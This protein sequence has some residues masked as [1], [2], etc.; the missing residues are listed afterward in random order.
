M[1]RL[2]D[3]K[4]GASVRGVLPDC[5]VTVVNAQWFGSEGLELTYKK[6]GGKVDNGLLYRHDE[7]RLEIVEQGRPWSFDADGHL[8]RLV[9]E[10]RRISLAHI[11]DPVLAVHTSIVDPHRTRSRPYMR[12]F[13]RASR[14]VSSWPTTR[15][16]ARPS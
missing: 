9:S 2:E 6:P 3:L 7:P 12:P 14:S 1:A 16:P 4:Q 10:A 8:F 5:L 15:A 13:C 11:F